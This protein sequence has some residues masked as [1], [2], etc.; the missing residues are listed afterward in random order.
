MKAVC[1]ASA[2][3]VAHAPHPMRET[4][5]I[6]RQDRSGRSWLRRDSPPRRQPELSTQP[7]VLCLDGR[8]FRGVAHRDAGARART[9]WSS[10]LAIE[11][12]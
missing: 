12:T 8:K 1:V 5:R 11:G 7:V 6:D 2:R 4:R 3:G 9:Q 10:Q